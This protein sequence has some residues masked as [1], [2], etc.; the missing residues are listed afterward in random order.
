MRRRL[1]R[2]FRRLAPFKI[3]EGTNPE[4]PGKGADPT[5]NASGAQ[6]QAWRWRSTRH[7]P[8]IPNLFAAAP[9]IEAGA[10]FWLG[11]D[12][13][14]TE[15]AVDVAQTIIHNSGFFRNGVPNFWSAIGKLP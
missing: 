4:P 15:T 10:G 2:T 5:S 1:T 6:D 7:P 12:R 9:S 8:S 13:G 3:L 14:H 11:Q